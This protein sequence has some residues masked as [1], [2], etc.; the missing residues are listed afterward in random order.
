MLPGRVVSTHCLSSKAISRAQ[1]AA[2]GPIGPHHG[3]RDN[4]VTAVRAQTQ[5]FKVP[6]Y[7]ACNHGSLVLL[8][9]PL[10]QKVTMGAPEKSSPIYL[11]ACD[12]FTF[13][14]VY[15]LLGLIYSMLTIYIFATDISIDS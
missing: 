15:P 11:H 12:I 14:E 13:I 4:R 6:T 8:H 5:S 3:P 2:G 10:G 1:A 9:G 7:I